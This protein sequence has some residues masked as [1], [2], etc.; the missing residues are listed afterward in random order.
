MTG[1]TGQRLF[2][3]IMCQY[4]A[5]ISILVN[6][7]FSK[8]N[9]LYTICLQQYT[10][11]TIFSWCST[12]IALDHFCIWLE[13][14]VSCTH[15]YTDNTFIHCCCESLFSMCHIVLPFI[16]QTMHN[17][18]IERNCIMVRES[19][20]NLSQFSKIDVISDIL[21]TFTGRFEPGPFQKS[22]LGVCVC[23]IMMC[24]YWAASP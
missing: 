19:N 4:Q 8:H 14:S 18:I 12:N 7:V 9:L 17:C 22:E 21:G 15:R 20:S 10:Y 16:I 3:A 5:L 23:V 1:I 13:I 2:F 24:Y 6:I 11:V